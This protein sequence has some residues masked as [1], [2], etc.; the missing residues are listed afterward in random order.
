MIFLFLEYVFAVVR[1]TSEA[2]ILFTQHSNIASS[3]FLFFFIQ[4]GN[5][6]GN[7]SNEFSS[8]FFILAELIEHAKK[9]VCIAS[10]I[11]AQTRG[12][13]AISKSH[14]FVR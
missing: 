9:C 1:H 11:I 3:T 4:F 13:H 12:I 8:F 6:F 5:P 2:T 14:M 7:V 10:H